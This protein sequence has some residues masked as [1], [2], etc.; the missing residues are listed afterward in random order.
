[1]PGAAWAYDPEALCKAPAASEQLTSGMRLQSELETE[2]ARDAYEN[3]LKL[4]P[5]CAACRYELGWSFWKLGEWENV[6]KTWEEVLKIEPDHPLVAQYLPTARE[7]LALLRQ[8]KIPPAFR[9]NVELATVSKP[10]DGPVS[11]IFSSRRQSYD[12]HPTHPL[13]HYDPEIAS[14]KSVRFSQDGKKV[15]VNSLEA[16]RTVIY[17]AFGFTKTGSIRHKFDEDSSALFDRSRVFGYRFPKTVKKPN[18]FFGKPVEL[19]LTHGGRYLWA[20]YYR[21][22]FDS[23]GTMPSAVAIIDTQTDKI[24]RVMGTGPI[25]KYVKASPKGNWLAISHWGDNTVGLIDI[26][27]NDP[28]KFKRMA[29]LTVEKKMPLEGVKGDRDKE[30]GFC[31]RGLAFTPDEHYLFVSRMKGGGVAVFDLS[32]FPAKRP[33]YLGSLFGILPGPRDLE[34]SRDGS[35]LY[36]SCN[37]SGFVARVPVEGMIEALKTAEPPLKRVEIKRKELGTRVAYVGLGA[38]SIRLSPDEKHLFV[39]V[40]QTSEIVAVDTAAMKAEARIPVDS[41]PVGLDLSPDGGQLWVTSQGRS[42]KGGNSVGV[43]QVR[44]RNSEVIKR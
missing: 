40:N 33:R 10:E 13:D 17:D 27:G 18:E 37:A 42:A 19:E 32:G 9:S 38:R 3:C 36:M 21:R 28:A 26:R 2:Q 35:E 43:F 41:Y 8:K 4:E 34:M 12:P 23:L 5:G 20:P 29:L 1:L 44:Y 14:P 31:V 22:S 7:N 30:C 16:G 24:V 15:Y 6:I 25:S 39:A 11:L